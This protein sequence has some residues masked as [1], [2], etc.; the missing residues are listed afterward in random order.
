M[1]AVVIIPTYN[2]KENIG[3]LIDA[4]Q[5]V[6]KTIPEHRMG[7]LVV[8][9]NSPDGTR[10]MVQSRI[11]GHDNV[12]LLTEEKKAGLGAA[13]LQGMAHADEVLGAEVVFEF[14]ADFSHDP[15][16]IPAFMAAIECGADLVLGSRYIPGGSIPADWGPHRKFLSV[17][18]NLV[19]RLFF[20]NA[21]KDW[22]TG[23]RAIRIE[24]Y[25]A[26]KGAI[27]DFKGYTFQITFLHH[28][29]RGG[30]KIAEVPIHFIDRTRGESK[31]GAEYM[32]QTML[33][34][35]RTRWRMLRGE[36]QGGAGDHQ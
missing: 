24:V 11:E 23:Y 5:D 18:G 4:L 10:E 8:D 14:D 30:F 9:G 16:R 36:K 3:R 29:L 32:I 22:T 28:A 6:F 31:L 1:N 17:V 26:V 20:G 35:I 7:V 34:L 2:E 25:R 13:Y 21:I 33:F 12:W 19:V 15:S 27:T